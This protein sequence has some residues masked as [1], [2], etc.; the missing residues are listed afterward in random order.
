GQRWFRDALVPIS[1][2]VGRRLSSEQVV[3]PLRERRRLFSDTA[4]ADVGSAAASVRSHVG[5]AF[6]GDDPEADFAEWLEN[7]DGSRP[8]VKLKRVS[9]ESQRDEVL[10]TAGG[11]EWLRR[12]EG[13]CLSGISIVASSSGALPTSITSHLPAEYL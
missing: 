2:V 6:A 4:F 9:W 3:T 8:G 10:A 5:N 7:G 13:E 12:L 1:L 11:T